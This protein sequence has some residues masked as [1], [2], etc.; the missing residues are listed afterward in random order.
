VLRIGAHDVPVAVPLAWHRRRL[1]WSTSV[2]RVVPTA[3]RTGDDRR[4]GG[5]GRGGLLDRLIPGTVGV[6][7]SDPVAGEEVRPGSTVVLRVA[8]AC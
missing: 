6:C 4:F 1:L 8:R 3:S 7:D 2:L 5:L